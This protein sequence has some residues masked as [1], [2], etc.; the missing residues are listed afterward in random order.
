M[1]PI[2]VI[3]DDLSGA[4]E[5]AGIAVRHGLTAEV[6]TTLEEMDENVCDVVC[7]DTDTR[8]RPSDEA[9]AVVEAAT[10]RVMTARP[11]W[12][13]KKCDSVLR[14]SVVEEA[15]AVARASG[16]KNILLA[17]AN[18]TRG[19]VIR[20]G[21]YFVEGRSLHETAFA[22]DPQHPRTSSRVQDLVGQGSVG[23][24]IPDVESTADLDRLAAT[25]SA[26]TLPVGAA[27]FFEALLR[28][29]R[30]SKPRIAARVMTSVEPTRTRLLVCGSAF[31]WPERART[32][33]AHGITVATLHRGV[34]EATKAL[35]ESG[36]A[37]M[38]IGIDAET[39]G[40]APEQ[41]AQELA[42]LV[43]QVLSEA[44]L[45]LLL[46]EGGATAA[47]V[48]R[49]M[50]WVR[51]RAKAGRDQSWTEFVPVGAT[52]PALVIKPGSYPWPEGLWP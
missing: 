30:I 19:R 25:M 40:K 16:V 44:S 39:R 35:L 31:A 34:D 28:A 5:L 12:I 45:D 3:A 2:V 43:A 29:K 23:I 52:S 33:D 14:G 27:D 50:N 49:R 36:R 8:A 17:P 1:N 46:L 47:A 4:A 6:R 38:G 42:D 13:F 7:V 32:A 51:L 26:N 37:V 15:S 20:G 11:A 10:R 21:E 24:T 41:L 18:P 22:R 9:A 48:L